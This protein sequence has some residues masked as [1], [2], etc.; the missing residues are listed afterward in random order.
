MYYDNSNI[1]FIVKYSNCA[2]K[3]FVFKRRICNFL[4]IKHLCFKYPIIQNLQNIKMEKSE[5]VK[6]ELI[7]SIETLILNFVPGCFGVPET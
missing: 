4:R 1:K 5:R 2:K 6:S 3:Q 7:Q